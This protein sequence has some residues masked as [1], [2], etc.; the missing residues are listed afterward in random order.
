MRGREGKGWCT[1]GAVERWWG[2]LMERVTY[3]LMKTR[4]LGYARSCR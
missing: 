4:L 2:V 3:D 1:V